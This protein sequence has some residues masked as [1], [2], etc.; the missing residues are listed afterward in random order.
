VALTAVIIG[1]FNVAFRVL[2]ATVDLGL[3]M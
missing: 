3:V 2:C 1:A